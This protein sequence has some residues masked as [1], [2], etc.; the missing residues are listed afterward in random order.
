[1]KIKF[2][3]FQKQY[4]NHQ[5][6]FD[7]TTKRVLSSGWYVLGKQ[8]AGFEKKFSDYVGTKYAVGVANGME[9]LQISLMAL[10]IGPGDEVITTSHTAVATAFA[11]VSVGAKPVFVDIDGYFHID[12]SKIE[13]KITKKTKAILPVHLYGQ[14]VDLGKIMFICKKYKIYLIEDCAQA[15]GATYKNKKLGSLGIVNCFSF[16]PTKNLGAFGDGGAIT[17]NDKALYEKILQLRNYGQKNRYEH[18]VYGLNSRLDEIQAAILLVQLKYLDNN[19]KTRQKLAEVYY[20][21]LQK[22]KE[23]KLPALRRNSKSV[24]HLFVI[25]VEDRKGLVEYLKSKGVSTL[26]HYPIPTHKQKCFLKHSSVKLAVLEKKV[27]KILSLPIHP[28]LKTKE[29]EYVCQ[30]IKNFYNL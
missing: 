10:K 18:E 19:N 25:E 29:V 23:I 4:Q 13:E 16:Y 5:K 3:D 7:S 22:V 27:K 21:N 30:H 17:T 1:M 9:A 12:A 11:I 6:E 28:F 20:K 26:I 2:N 24:F 15:H 14:S 8:V